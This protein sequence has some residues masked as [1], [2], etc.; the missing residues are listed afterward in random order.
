[1][2]SIPFAYHDGHVH[3]FPAQWQ[4]RIYQWFDQSGWRL[5]YQNLLEESIW[6]HIRR[7]GADGASILIYA[8]RPGVAREMNQWLFDW[9]KNRPDLH[10]YGTVH[11][12]DPDLSAIV[13]QAL[14]EFRFAGFK[15]HANVQMVRPDDPRLDPLYEAVI[16]R[17]RSVVVHAGREPHPNH[18]VGF[19]YFKNVLTRFPTLR[20]QV[21]HLGVDETDDFV[22]LLDQ[23]PNVFLDTAGVPGTRLNL[24]DGKLEKIIQSFPN[25]II[26]GS[27]MP[28]LEESVESHRDRIW[29]AAASPENQRRIFRGNLERFWSGSE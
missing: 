19:Q 27:D 21:A 2:S 11:P 22:T 1:M 18:Y 23:Y 3:V 12:D 9:A 14:D 28:I 5:F 16:D 17:H 25:Q 10:L 15:I 13:T 4:R 20:V 24:P 26:Y 7:C 8:H 29:K 6:Q